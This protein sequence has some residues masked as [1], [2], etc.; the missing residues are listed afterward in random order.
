MGQ[1][2]AKNEEENENWQTSVY[3]CITL[4]SNYEIQKKI[5]HCDRGL[6]DSYYTSAESVQQE[7]VWTSD[8]LR[9]RDDV[10]KMRH[11]AAVMLGRVGM[12]AR[13]MIN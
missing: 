4:K 5:F 1:G 3:V 6:Q 7:R 10:N 2:R 13:S 12:I 9:E 11:T 8:F